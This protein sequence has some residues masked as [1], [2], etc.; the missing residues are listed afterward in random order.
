MLCPT[1][2]LAEQHFRTFIKRFEGYPFTV[3]VLD[4]FV[5]PSV[6]AQ[7]IKELKDGTIDILI[8]TH[9]ILSKDVQFKDLGLLIVDE[10]QRFGVEHKEKI[11][12]MKNG[13]DVL[14]L[15]AT[16]IPRTLQ[17][18]LVGIRSLSQLE[19]PPVNRYSVQTYVVEKNEGLIG[20]AIE[21]EL[22]RNGQ[23][24]YLYNNI[25][26]IYNVTRRL[27][28][29]IPEA[30][31]GIAHGKMDRDEIEDVMMRF[32]NRELNVLVCTTI[33]ENGID[34]PNVNTIIIDNAQDFGLA[35][36]YQIKGR[37]GRS[38]RVAYAYLMVPPRK[39]LSETA[40]KR[41]Q[42]VKE[43]ARLG[44]GYKIAMRDLTIRGAG[45]LL[46][47]NQSGFIDTVGIDM[48]IE[49]LE[50]AIEKKK[51]IVKEV[52]PERKQ[53]NVH[54][55]SYIP[56]SFAPDDYDKIGLYQK[57]DAVEN[58]QQLDDYRNEIIDQYGKLPSE[59]SAVFDK[60]HLDI[61]I[62][63]PDVQGY[64]EKNGESE[65]TFSPLF[66]NQVD[67][68]K[69][70]EIFSKLSKD[71]GL[72]YTNQCIIASL[73]KQKDSLMLVIQMIEQAKGAKRS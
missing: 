24:F 67:G 36:I 26:Q 68:V 39:Q 21:K 1:T 72:R 58:V 53:A 23:V 55:T 65:V 57:I 18:S 66:S 50:E 4:R 38:D 71:I 62:N 61:L 25:E 20:D 29:L 43:F 60:K 16:P 30:K 6:Q 14:A 3:R 31:I 48:Y 49:M 73:P 41:L 63:D 15:S 45:D 13:I 44:S 64:R 34:I 17:M 28:N 37:V 9:R 54:E 35:Q 33:I 19:T 5:Q 52:K 69:L 56:H 22:A 40:S 11:K 12:E 59:V 27:Q 51:G 47:E 7:I 46:G 70:F 2:I 8:G 10:E 42:A 32:N